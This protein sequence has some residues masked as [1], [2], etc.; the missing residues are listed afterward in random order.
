MVVP[1]NR[2]ILRTFFEDDIIWWTTELM[3]WHWATLMGLAIHLKQCN[4][5]FVQIVLISG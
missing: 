5:N 3:A 2:C 1:F 4:A